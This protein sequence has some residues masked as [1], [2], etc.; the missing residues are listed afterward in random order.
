M[1]DYLLPMMDQYYRGKDQIQQDEAMRSC[2][3]ATQTLMLTA[4]AMGY[5]SVPMDASVLHET[6]NVAVV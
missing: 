6:R 2:G 5:G 1:Q 3:M 4:K